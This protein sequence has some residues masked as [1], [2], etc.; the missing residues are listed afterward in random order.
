MVMKRNETDEIRNA[1]TKV[2]HWTP[3][4][5][6]G[7]LAVRLGVAIPTVFQAPFLSDM[8]GLDVYIFGFLVRRVGRKTS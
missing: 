3:T 7:F 2:Q 5:A 6:Y 1:A 4:S 8:G